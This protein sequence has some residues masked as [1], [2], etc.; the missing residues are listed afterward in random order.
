[1]EAVIYLITTKDGL[2][3]GS[4]TN[5]KMRCYKHKSDLNTGKLLPVYENIRKNNGE[6]KI[7]IILD[8][9]C[10][11]QIELRKIEEEYR[12]SCEANLNAQ[13]AYL[14]IDDALSK[15]KSY[16]QINKK[17]ILKTKAE[18]IDCVCGGKYTCSNKVRHYKTLRHQTYLSSL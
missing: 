15:K 13:S 2:Y 1:M 12:V 6:Y 7:E 8:L 18:K 14:S 16:Y 9:V 11:N 17:L 10:E 4:T 5:F 3:I